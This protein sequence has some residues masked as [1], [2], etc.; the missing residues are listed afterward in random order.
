MI[1]I[2]TVSTFPKHHILRQMFLLYSNS[3]FLNSLLRYGKFLVID[4]MQVDMLEVIESR[5]DEIQ[6]GLF[7]NLLDKSILQNDR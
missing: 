1:S 3:I 5:M 2:Y 7:K 4:M 6:K